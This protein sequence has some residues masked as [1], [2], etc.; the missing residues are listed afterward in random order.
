M[1]ITVNR[2][3][4]AFELEQDITISEVLEHIQKWAGEQK[5]FILNYQ[6][7]PLKEVENLAE[8]NLLSSEIN[9]LEVEVGTQN[10][11]YRENLV[12]L[13]RYLEQIGYFIANG[14]QEG[15]KLNEK[16]IAIVKEGLSW[17]IESVRM[18][19]KQTKFIPDERLEEILEALE[20]FQNIEVEILEQE[21]VLK[22]LDHLGILKNYVA[23]FCPSL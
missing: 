10:D 15:R 5:L 11:L 14:L 19:G 18:L 21:P 1:K 12:E 7:L 3:P 17:I 6:I 4:I 20:K 16:E 2:E 8:E 23:I 9:T 13:D 22:F